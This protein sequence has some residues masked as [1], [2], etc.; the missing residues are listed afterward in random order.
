MSVYAGRLAAKRGVRFPIVAGLVIG[1]AGFFWLAFAAHAGAGYAVILLPL[2]SIGAG[3][4]LILPPGTSVGL[5]SGKRP[6]VSLPSAPLNARRPGGAAAGRVLFG[7]LVSAGL[8][9]VVGVP[10]ALIV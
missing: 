10:C 8:H 2:L 1:G 7:C 4:P 5:G 3:V 6:A 9:F